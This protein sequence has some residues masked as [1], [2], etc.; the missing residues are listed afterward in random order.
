MQ[1]KFYNMQ[2]FNNAIFNLLF[3]LRE[4]STSNISIIHPEGITFP[5]CI[6]GLM[7]NSQDS[8]TNET[9]FDVILD[10]PGV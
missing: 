6:G 9:V 1:Q 3:E 4:K 2:N 5:V 10:Y 7:Y 8:T